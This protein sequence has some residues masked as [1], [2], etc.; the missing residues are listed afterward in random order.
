MEGQ[1]SLD[2]T[3][4]QLVDEEA[5]DVDEVGGGDAEADGEQHRV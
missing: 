1:R 4:V 5:D 2:T 3:R